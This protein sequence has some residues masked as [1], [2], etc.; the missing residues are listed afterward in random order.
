M[1]ELAPVLAER[2]DRFVLVT[3]AAGLTI[4]GIQSMAG[5]DYPVLRVMP[6]TP[7]SIGEGMILYTPGPGVTAAETDSFLEAMAGAGRFSPIP[8]RLMDA[9]H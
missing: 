8:E 6:N 7:C 2:T 5:G 9:E 3:M 4:A 1:K